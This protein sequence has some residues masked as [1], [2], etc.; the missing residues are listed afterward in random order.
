M[1]HFIMAKMDSEAG[2]HY[3]KNTI[4]FLKYIVSATDVNQKEKSHFL[5]RFNS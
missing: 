1:K 4:K 2:N 3:N 5:D